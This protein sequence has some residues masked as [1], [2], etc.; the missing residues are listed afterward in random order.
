MVESCHVLL[1]VL[2]NVEIQNLTSAQFFGTPTPLSPSAKSVPNNNRFMERSVFCLLFVS[3]LISCALV[4]IP[5]HDERTLVNSNPT[6][7]FKVLSMLFHLLM[8]EESLWQR[9]L[10][11]HYTRQKAV[12]IRLSNLCVAGGLIYLPLSLQADITLLQ[13][14][15]TVK[16]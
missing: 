3:K 1:L 6:P 16:E 5:I 7:P 12:T 15:G 14:H 13:K 9:F 11:P 10:S 8:L 2:Q 4:T